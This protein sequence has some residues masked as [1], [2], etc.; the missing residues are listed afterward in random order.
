MIEPLAT[1]SS[2]EDFLWNQ[3]KLSSDSGPGRRYGLDMS[4]TVD[5]MAGI[6]IDQALGPYGLW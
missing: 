6:I 4:D 3:V 5:D 1:I 2:L